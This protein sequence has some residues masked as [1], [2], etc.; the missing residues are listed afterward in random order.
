MRACFKP[1]EAKIIAYASEY[2]DEDDISIRVLERSGRGHYSNFVSQTMIPKPKNQLMRIYPIFHFIPG[3]PDA[4]SA[5]RRDDKMHILNTTPNSTN[6]NELIDGAFKS[7]E[8]IRLY[9]IGIATHGYVDT[10]AH[11][12]YVDWYDYFNNIG[13]DVKPDIGHAD[14]AHHP[15]WVG[16]YREDIRLVDSEVSNRSRFTSAAEALFKK[17]CDYLK[18]QRRQESSSEW[19]TFEEELL[20]IQGRTNSGNQ[21]YYEEDCLESYRKRLPRW[22]EFDEKIWSTKPSTPRS[23]G[24]PTPTRG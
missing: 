7:T 24:Y 3:E 13:L 12:N 2:V 22:P 5:N 8:D 18:S 1:E 19:S 15:D 23:E 10:W 16:H 11:Q 14:G 17:Y 4:P 21:C 20:L 6:A 9:R